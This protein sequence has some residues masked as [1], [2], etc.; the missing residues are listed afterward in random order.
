MIY[1]GT[2]QRVA[3]NTG[4]VIIGNVISRLI[5]LV[6]IIYLARYLGIVG[7]GKFT[8]VFA[9]L[10][11]FMLLPDLGLQNILVRE[12][13]RNPSK[14][15]NV[16]GNSYIIRLILS[17]I[18]IVLSMI[19]ITFVSYPEDTKTYVYIAAFTLLFQSFSNLHS[20]LFI[21]NLRMEYDVYAKLV[22]RILSACL[23]LRVIFLH[24]TLAQIMAIMVFS[25][26][27]RML[28]SYMFSRKFVK[29]RFE[30]DL[31]LWK[32][33]IKESLPLALSAAIWTLY[34]YIDIVM[35]SPMSGDD[36]VGIYSAAH[37]LV[38]PFSLIPMAVMV[39]LFPIMSKSFK[40][41]EDIILK[42]YRLSIKY[43]LIIALPVAIGVIILAD[44]II[45]LIYGTNF[46]NST[47]VLRIL[48]IA[49]V[50]TFMYFVLLNILISIDKQKLN[51]LSSGMGAIANVI[52][53]FMLIP[54]L[55]YNGAAIATLATY[56][57]LFIASFYFVSKHLQTIPIHKILIKPVISGLIMGAFIYYFTELNMFLLVPLAG[58]VY[59]VALVA[60]RTF[61]EEDWD[62]KK[63]IIKF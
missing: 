33:L 45:L 21:A 29:P 38:E 63:K 56:T 58:I 19:T 34:H 50:F 6:V 11:F 24:G 5:S 60:L 26:V 48:I 39:S 18:A 57:V 8:F 42:S 40:K 10:A 59:L 4:I 28:I 20:S 17:I 49:I 15:P 51:T 25:E 37:K 54:I 23:I 22:F 13:S 46:V 7:F 36:A 30:I 9:Y 2:V 14:A 43:L 47:T 31:G 62:I 35:L 61:T 16:I 3:K 41:S 52:L 55:S 53:N 1:L 44:R 12:I 32:Y 27:I